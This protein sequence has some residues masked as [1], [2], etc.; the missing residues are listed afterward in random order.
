M[1]ML[2]LLLHCLLM[3]LNTIT[4]LQHSAGPEALFIWQRHQ[5]GEAAAVQG[6]VKQLISSCLL[7]CSQAV[8]AP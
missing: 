2:M 5:A 4:R 3:R 7:T 1:R 6:V 8:P